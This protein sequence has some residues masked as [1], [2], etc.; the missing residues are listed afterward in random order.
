MSK[1]IN[2]STLK[3]LLNHSP[4]HY[5]HAVTNPSPDTPALVLGRAVHSLVLEPETFPALYTTSPFKDFR[6]KEAQAWRDSQTAAILTPSDWA[7]VQAMANALLALPC[8]KD[9][10]GDYQREVTKEWEYRGL[11]CKG[12]LDLL[13]PDG[14][15]VV[16]IKTTADAYPA[17]FARSSVNYGY[18]FQ[19]A[20]YSLPTAATRVTFIAIEKEPP[21]ATGVYTMSPAFLALGR[22]KVDRAIDILQACLAHN[23]FPAYGESTL[24]APQWAAVS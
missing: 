15:H 2:Q 7:T 11:P 17:A 8:L 5:L 18:D 12:R 14:S 16:D 23:H 4:A 22:Q 21:F 24:E 3:V 9:W 13:S 6:T 1:R 10:L 19:G 20:F